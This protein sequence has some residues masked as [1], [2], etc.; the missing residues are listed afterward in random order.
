[1]TVSLIRKNR[2]IT[3]DGLCERTGADYGEVSAAALTL[4]ADG[5]IDI[6]LLQRCTINTKNL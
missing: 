1:M 2:G 3:L 5:I 4:Q 6:D